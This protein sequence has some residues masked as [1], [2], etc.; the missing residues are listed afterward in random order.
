MFRFKWADSNGKWGGIPNEGG[1]GF[2]GKWGTIP[3]SYNGQ[4]DSKGVI[5][6]VIPVKVPHDWK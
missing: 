5:N 4:T 6:Q 3:A 2:D 1:R